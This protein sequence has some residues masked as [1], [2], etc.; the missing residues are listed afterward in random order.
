MSNQVQT[1]DGN[2]DEAGVHRAEMHGTAGHGTASG[3]DRDAAPAGDVAATREGRTGGRPTMKDVAARAGVALKTVSRV[4][5]SEPGVTPETAGRV[6]GAIEELG[7]RRNESARL[8]RTGRTAT[9]GFI[10]GSWADPDDVAVYQGVESVAREQGYLMYAGSTDSDPARE[11]GLALAMCARRVDGLIIIPAPGSH[12]Y[13][14]SEIEAGVA[15]VSVLHPP[16][17][18]RADSVLPDA[19]GAAQAAVAHLAA[20]GHRRIGLVGGPAGEQRAALRDG[21]GQAMAAAG[22]PADP[23]WQALDVAAL[24]GPGLP[25]TAVFCASQ[26]LT[27]AALRALAARD[28]GPSAERRVAVVGFGDFELAD[29]LSPPVTVVSYDPV[30]IGSTACELL[31]GRLAGQQAPPRPVEVPVR[32]IARGSAEFPPPGGPLPR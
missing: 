29:V 20:H 14:A 2:T 5:N 4:V 26:A 13:L 11:E 16:E 32:L 8:L 10:A 19:R 31:L 15:T 9:L 21:Y 17:L 18:A 1:V 25:V 28:G 24:A 7:F 23:A 30:L 12:D 22:L 27:R 3:P 6:L